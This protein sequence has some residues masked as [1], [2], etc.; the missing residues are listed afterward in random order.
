MDLSEKF[1][2]EFMGDKPTGLKTTLY[3][4]ALLSTKKRMLATRLSN[5]QHEKKL[6][7]HKI[8]QLM[9]LEKSHTCCQDT[10]VRIKVYATE[11]GRDYICDKCNET[12]KKE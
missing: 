3:S 6:L 10:D 1:L 12:L 8:H 11:T 5:M 4:I 2:T 7:G 9:K